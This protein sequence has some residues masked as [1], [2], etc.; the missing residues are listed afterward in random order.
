MGRWA[1]SEAFFPLLTDRRLPLFFLI[2]LSDFFFS[3]FRYGIDLG[4]WDR[5]FF[6]RVEIIGRDST[7]KKKKKF[8]L[9]L[10][11]SL[12]SWA[13]A[14]VGDFVFFHFRTIFDYHISRFVILIFFRFAH[15]LQY[16]TRAC[17]GEPKHTRAF[18]LTPS[19]LF[20]LSSARFRFQIVNRGGMFSF[21]L[22]VLHVV[23]M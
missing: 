9:S 20:F 8:I 5:I 16:H 1:V 2:A 17:L 6:S 13:H 12:I 4:F 15:S 23:G 14:L 18:K 21:G 7:E 3:F 22:Y 11:F 10:P 19:F